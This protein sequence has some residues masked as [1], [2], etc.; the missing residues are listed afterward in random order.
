[1]STSWLRHA[2]PPRS[3]SLLS[4]CLLP[5]CSPP[6][7]AFLYPRCPSNLLHLQPARRRPYIPLSFMSNYGNQGYNPQY[8]PPPTYNPGGSQPYAQPYA[9]PYPPPN[10]GYGGDYKDPYEGDRFKPKKRINDPIFLVLFIAQVGFVH[11]SC[12]AGR[13]CGERC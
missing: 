3:L 2:S 6:G 13:A 8:A 10:N 5:P 4:C 9:P 7:L 11:E 1:M 12:E